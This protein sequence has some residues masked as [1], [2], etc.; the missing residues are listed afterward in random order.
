M[1]I[2]KM[3]TLHELADEMGLSHGRLRQLCRAA[4]IQGVMVGT[5]R[6][7]APADV[8]KIKAFPRRQY[9]KQS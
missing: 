8:R 3:Q 4:K 9:V 5:T 7:L 1:N 6:L 2:N